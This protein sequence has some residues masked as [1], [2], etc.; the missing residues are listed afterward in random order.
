M[1]PIV[2]PILKRRFPSCRLHEIRY[3]VRRPMARTSARSR[4]ARPKPSSR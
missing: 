3:D 1:A 2:A 4:Q